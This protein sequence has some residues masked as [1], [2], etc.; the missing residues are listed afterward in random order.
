MSQ[1]AHNLIPTDHA[2]QEKARLIVYG[3]NDPDF[4]ATYEKLEENRREAEGDK[5][6]GPRTRA[7]GERERLIARAA[8]ATD[9]AADPS[10]DPDPGMDLNSLIR[11]EVS[12]LPAQAASSA[13]EATTLRSIDP[14]TH[15]AKHGLRVRV[16]NAKKDES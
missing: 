3:D 11:A 2:L 6:L 8:R 9:P 7:A 13:P 10:V 14:T 16:R 5:R 4:V 1:K 12:D 15:A